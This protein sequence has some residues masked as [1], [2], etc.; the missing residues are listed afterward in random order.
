MALTLETIHATMH[1]IEKDLDLFQRSTAGVRAW[2]LI[3]FA[4]F[5]NVYTN[6]SLFRSTSVK[7]PPIGRRAMLKRCGFI[8]WCLVARN[9]FLS[10]RR[11]PVVIFPHQRQVGDVD[12]YSEWLLQH[13]DPDKRLVLYNNWTGTQYDGAKNMSLAYLCELFLVRRLKHFVLVTG[14]D[15][16]ALRIKEE[17]GICLEINRMVA[18]A[19]VRFKMQ[20]FFYYWLFKWRRVEDI[21]IVV[22]YFKE[23]IIAAAQ[24]LGIRVTELQ[25]GFMSNNHIGYGFPP[26]GEVPYFADRLFVFGEYWRRTTALPT[27]C[28]TQVVGA[29][30]IE[31][32][33]HK[34]ASMNK[35]EKLIL[36]CSQLTIG[37]KLF[38]VACDVARLLP[39]YTVL[40]RLHPSEHHSMYTA[41]LT[42]RGVDKPDN[43]EFSSGAQD[44]TYALLARATY[45]VGVY[46]T[47]LWEGLAFGCKTIVLDLPGS[48]GA[49]PLVERH[50]AI[51]VKDANDMV[52]HLHETRLVDDYSDYYAPFTIPSI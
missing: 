9:P 4:V 7:K 3:R 2:K 14:Y 21:F 42:Q 40:Y 38:A 29:W 30:Y 10:L 1:R 48:G 18:V 17:T 26:G 35:Q 11:V 24:Q 20:R 22:G 27:T 37:E 46:S 31:C 36:Y 47:T 32:M 44:D 5:T 8:L 23:G 41:Y 51:M 13:T 52:A 50:H 16:V 43:L 49:M 12:I 34:Y 39:D 28:E 33:R 19:V 25:H 45:N 15:D 6:I